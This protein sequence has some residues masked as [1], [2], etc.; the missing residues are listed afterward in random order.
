MHNQWCITKGFSLFFLFWL[1]GYA[2]YL[3]FW[4]VL[5]V[6]YLTTFGPKFWPKIGPKWGFWPKR[7][8][9]HT[10]QIEMSCNMQNQQKTNDFFL[11]YGPETMI[12]DIFRPIVPIMQNMSDTVAYSCVTITIC[13]IKSLPCTKLEKMRFAQKMLGHAHAQILEGSIYWEP[14]FSG[15]EIFRDGFS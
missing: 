13:N 10:D 2:W 3:R 8:F 7:G 9:T 5:N 14:N 1:I 12:L 6:K 15:S 4:L 11:R